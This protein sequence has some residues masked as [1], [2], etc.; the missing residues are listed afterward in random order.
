L[1]AWLISAMVLC[2]SHFIVPLTLGMMTNTEQL[3][4]ILSKEYQ[5]N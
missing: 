1:L 2:S 4:H 5:Q 3:Q